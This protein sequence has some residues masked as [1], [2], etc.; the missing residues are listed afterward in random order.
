MENNEEL[1]VQQRTYANLPWGLVIAVVLVWGAYF[2]VLPVIRPESWLVFLLESLPL[3]FLTTWGAVW[4]HNT[5]REKL[6]QM[7]D[8]IHFTYRDLLV[9]FRKEIKQ[10]E[11]TRTEEETK[12]RD[13]MNR[14]NNVTVDAV[15]SAHLSL[16][17]NLEEF[18]KKYEKE[19]AYW[20]SMIDKEVAD[21]SRSS[22]ELRNSIDEFFVMERKRV[23][24]MHAKLEKDL[25]GLL[26]ELVPK[27]VEGEL[28]EYFD[29][30]R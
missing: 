27:S 28:N 1:P 17:K 10:F 20:Q 2:G 6:E 9:S 22:Q 30:Q 23:D 11:R 25:H 5:V 8:H 14:R 13:D 26:T 21:R 24:T 7:D 19:R 16:L 18:E 12:L 29:W 3:V 15:Q 4:Y